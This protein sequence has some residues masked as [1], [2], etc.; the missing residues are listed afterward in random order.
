MAPDGK[1]K[2]TEISPSHH[3]QQ[4]GLYWG[5][6]RVNDRDYFHHPEGDYWRKVSSK[7]NEQP[8]DSL[9]SW[10]IV[11]N[12]LDSAGNAVLTETQVWTMKAQNGQYDLDLEW[13]GEAKT[14]VTIGKYD[15]GGLFIRMPWKEGVRSEVINA[16]RQR[17]QKAEGQRSMWIDLGM[18]V[19]GRD[20]LAHIAM[21]DHPENKGYPQYWRVDNEFGVG[22][23]WARP[24]DRKIAKGQVEIL[25]HH[26]LFYTG[27]FNK[28]LFEKPWQEFAG[29]DL[30]DA[31]TRLWTLAREE[32]RDAKFLTPEEAVKNMTINDGYKINVWAAEPQITQPMAFCWDDRGRMWVA[33]NLDY[34]TR[35]TGFSNDGHSRILI[36]EDTNRDGK[37][38]TR[39]VFL[40]GIAFPSAIAVGFDGLYLG[41]PPNLLFVP[42]RNRDDKADTKDIEVRLT[43]WGIRDRHETINSLHWGP[44]GWLYGLQGFATPSKIKKPKGKGRIYKHRDKFPTDILEGEGVE[45]NGGVWRYHPTKDKFEVVA[46]GFSNPWGIDYDAKGQ[47]FITACVIPHLWYVIPGG[48]YHRQGGQHFNPYVYDDIKTI[49]DHSHRSAHGGARVYLSDA[50]PSSQRG[51]IFMANIHEHGILSD[52]LERKGS[53]FTGHHGD[54]FM[55]ANNAQ[56]VGFSVEIGPEGSL[57]V[58]DWHDADICGADVLNKETGRI[59]RISPEQSGSENF[60]GRY[61]DISKMGDAQLVQLQTSQSEWHARRAR[62]TLQYRA[63]KGSL[64]SDVNSKLKQMLSSETNADWRLRALWTLHVTNGLNGNELIALLDDKD[65]YIRA[66]AIQMLCEDKSPSK[67]T[68]QKFLTAASSDKSAVVR[69][70]LASALQRLDKSAK[71]DIA[72]KLLSHAEDSTDNNIPKML[73]FAVE[74]LVKDDASRFLSLTLESKIPLVTRFIARRAVDE[75]KL[76]EL[77]NLLGQS[78]SPKYEILSGMRDGLTGRFDI[79]VPAA[80]KN[81]YASLAKS[82]DKKIADM[83]ASVSQQFGDTEATARL[84]ATLRNANAPVDQ[85]RD[86][87]LQISNRQ[88][89]E[90]VPLLPDFLKN[91]DLKI[92]AIRAVAAYD[93]DDLGKK[94]LDMYPTSSSREKLEIIQTLSSRPSYGWMLTNAMRTKKIPKAEVPVYN[95]R[96]LLRVVGSGFLEVWGPLE[97][98][99]RDKI[100]YSKYKKL[101]NEKSLANASVLKGKEVF[102]NTCG[103]CHKLYNEGGA[104]GPDLTGSNRRNVDYLLAN[105]LEPSAEIQDDYKMVVIST[106]DGRNYSGN[107]VSQNER[108]V[109]LRIVGKDPVVLNKSAIQTMETTPVSMMPNGLLNNL[110]D[111]EILNLVSYLSSDYPVG[112]EGD[113]K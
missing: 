99:S 9:A 70:Y 47:I 93:E 8:N 19:D 5:M 55:M 51:R 64:S 52:V 66:W 54:D 29:I 108:Q 59:F 6:T 27:D 107:I 90:L 71:W 16:A 15:Y 34:E 98:T 22:P 62:I 12:L 49:A 89:D 21:F 104:I 24:E 41:A 4:T 110:T 101:L 95:A 1:G 91:P 68:I 57:Y 38:D 105:I 111:T 97:E 18:Q 94:L 80:W 3:K 26:L 7:V 75:N 53:G 31:E 39:K 77:M 43:G 28:S 56:F 113:K 10:E 48:I 102:M 83:A 35:G 42:D 84:L 14:D 88:L 58:L 92:D 106:R 112:K 46:H 36:L 60:D 23:A 86:A 20:D 17:N 69:L 78:G 45:I 74:P 67:E 65:E 63:S 33:E 25:K 50:F 109:T 82:G 100:A 2:Q 76:D 103:P 72:A 44:D 87:I 11:Y 96:Q 79:K 13:R 61:D 85:R 81:L 73:W 40:E 32:G 30:E 37:A